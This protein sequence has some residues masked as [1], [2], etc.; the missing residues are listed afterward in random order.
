MAVKDA[1]ARDST[2]PGGADEQG[3]A[4][5]L[6]TDL[7]RQILANQA[8]VMSALASVSQKTEHALAGLRQ[9]SPAL[10]NVSRPG[11]KRANN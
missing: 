8:R 5:N 1:V 7:L 6:P 4:G 3:S 10:Q 11:G 2:A 9:V